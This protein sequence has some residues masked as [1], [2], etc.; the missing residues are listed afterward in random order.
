L[1]AQFVIQH[2]LDEARESDKPFAAAGIFDGLLGIQGID[3]YL[4]SILYIAKGLAEP[5]SPKALHWLCLAMEW[6]IGRFVASVLVNNPELMRRLET[7][8][9]TIS[10]EEM[11]EKLDN[12]SDG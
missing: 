4:V 6:Y 12:G 7:A 2:L 1:K 9:E 3:L 10:T 11:E 5:A 8:G